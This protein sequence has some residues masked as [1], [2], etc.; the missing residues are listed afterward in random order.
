MYVGE[1]PSF[2]RAAYRAG[3]CEELW[4]KIEAIIVRA[5]R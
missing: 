4:E 5:P 2:R 3:L 1:H